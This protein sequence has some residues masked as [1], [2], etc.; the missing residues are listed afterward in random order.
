MC[1]AEP[2]IPRRRTVLYR[3]LTVFAHF[4]LRKKQGAE[5]VKNQ[6]WVD[7]AVRLRI[8]PKKKILE[9]AGDC[10]EVLGKSNKELWHQ[11]LTDALDPGS[12][13]LVSNAIEDL[14]H[15]RTTSR[16]IFRAGPSGEPTPFRLEVR[17]SGMQMVDGISVVLTALAPADRWQAV[18]EHDLI[19]DLYGDAGAFLDGAADLLSASDS[20]HAL[21]MLGLSGSAGEDATE[22][23]RR[24]LRGIVD[25]TALGMG[26]TGTAD[27]TGG[28]YGILHARD[29]DSAAMVAA[30]AD[31]A[32]ASGILADVSELV[33]TRLDPDGAGID[34]A[35][36]RAGID[37]LLDDLRD[38]HGHTLGLGEAAGMAAARAAN[39]LLSISSA[40]RAGRL[41]HRVQP[42]A[43]LFRD[44]VA[45]HEFRADPVVDGRVVT[46]SSVFAFI[47]PGEVRADYE[48]AVAARAL[49]WCATQRSQT[50]S[51]A[52]VMVPVAQDLLFDAGFRDRLSQ[53]V[54][55]SGL[56]DQDL[57]LR[58]YDPQS[59]SL[60]G[61][62]GRLVSELGS[63]S[64]PLCIADFA[65]FVA[66][67][68][69]RKDVVDTASDVAAYIE[70]SVERLR[71]L[72]GQPQ[73]AFLVQSLIETWR[74]RK[75][76]LLA[77]GVNNRADREVVDG[78]N[79][80]Y[81]RGRLVGDWNDGRPAGK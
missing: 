52:R 78:L 18:D 59:G 42:V 70:V 10:E 51:T 15:G 60:A 3:F 4:R 50:G 80:R 74:G 36:S 5:A 24:T 12:V 28:A 2:E 45:V 56:S 55:K 64:W 67:D 65:A 48:L 46:A 29:F 21:T 40:I 71:S 69:K 76:E 30:V 16:M 1:P 11:P 61:R 14:Y 47:D 23:A 26:A 7:S 39:D 37:G 58:P 41:R 75:I 73:G 66:I 34:P 8:S 25:R 33:S 44:R 20:G 62:G 19:A 17:R 22:G 38:G 79:V 43:S 68:A 77:S 9:V 13:I 32:V 72:T 63:F 81:A 49:S 6:P 57:V 31:E 54:A 27:L 35:H 53:V